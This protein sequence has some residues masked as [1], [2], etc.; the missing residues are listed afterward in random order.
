MSVKNW[1]YVVSLMK[2]LC[3]HPQ[4]IVFVETPGKNWL[5]FV[6]LFETRPE[7]LYSVNT[8]GQKNRLFYLEFWDR[9]IPTCFFC[10]YCP[11]KFIWKKISPV[12]IPFGNRG[13]VRCSGILMC[14]ERTSSRLQSS[15]AGNTRLWQRGPPNLQ[16][17]ASLT[18]MLL[19]HSTFDCSYQSSL[20]F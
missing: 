11:P 17:T 15:A 14:Y 13:G 1:V 18:Q 12:K 7:A 10:R 9:A 20:F 4:W 5:G 19:P 8:L 3:L 16:S 2:F 6:E